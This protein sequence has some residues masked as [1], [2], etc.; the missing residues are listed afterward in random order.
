MGSE[1]G[2]NTSLFAR[3][4]GGASGLV[5]ESAGSRSVGT[6]TAGGILDISF[7]DGVGSPIHNSSGASFTGGY[8]ACRS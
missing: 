3:Y 4:S 6:V 1:S 8:R 7:R 2:Y 5:T